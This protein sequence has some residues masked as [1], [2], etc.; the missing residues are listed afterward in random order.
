MTRRRGLCSRLAREAHP[1]FG[2]QT[3][4][5]HIFWQKDKAPITRKQHEGGTT[6]HNAR[7]DFSFYKHLTTNLSLVVD[8]R[9]FIFI[10]VSFHFVAFMTSCVLFV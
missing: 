1:V 8:K 5:F 9:R 10:F 7:A 4:F 3:N 2:K 6:T